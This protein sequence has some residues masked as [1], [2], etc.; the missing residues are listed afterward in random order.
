L[1]AQ[2]AGAESSAERAEVEVELNA[3]RRRA[4]GLRSQ[5][6]ALERRASFSRVSLRI[7]TGASPGGSGGGG[8]WGVGDGL[9]DAGRILAIAAGV[10]VIGLAALAPLALLVLLGWLAR[11]AWLRR[12]RASALA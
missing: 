9:G 4:A 1:L 6:S 11:R 2:L 5:L 10:T 7:E 3:E 8:N 12:A